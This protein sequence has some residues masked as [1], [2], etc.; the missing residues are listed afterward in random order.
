MSDG[1]SDTR[2]DIGRQLQEFARRFSGLWA[3]RAVEPDEIVEFAAEAVP[4]TI[5]AGLTLVR[6]DAR[7]ITLAATTELA[8]RV[9]ELEYDSGEGPCLD[10]IDDDDITAV[11][12]LER[13]PRW[14]KFSAKAI[15]ETPIRSMF[16]VRVF[17]GGDDRGALNFYAPEPGAFTDLDL[18]I[19]AMLSAMA[20]L[21]L[22][23]AVA[24]RK[25]DNLKVALESSR[26][27]GTAIG[28]LMSS[29]LITADRAF[30]ELRTV[31]QH[32]HRKIRD[33]AAEVMETGALPE[34]KPPRRRE[35]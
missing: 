15:E 31:S 10:A 34:A 4:H 35:G 25:T 21:A 6:G 14:P 33:V 28:I 29:R 19:G 12:D 3:G 11:A 9:D 18:G 16:G 27:I 23:N 32:T 24:Q 13:D 8:R 17:L 26:Q 30:D 20:S 22:Q 5:A 2:R 7:P 1:S